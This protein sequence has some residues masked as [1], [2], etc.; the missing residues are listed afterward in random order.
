MSFDLSCLSPSLRLSP[1]WVLL[2]REGET[3]EVTVS[4]FTE[5][6][7]SLLRVDSAA[8][9]VLAL[10]WE[11]EGSLLAREEAAVVALALE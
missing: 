6:K 8:V 3:E 2:A 10:V 1:P 11:D 5:D 9:E 4:C 7:W